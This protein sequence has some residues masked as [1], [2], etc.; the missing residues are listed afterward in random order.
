MAHELCERLY[1]LKKNPPIYF[2]QLVMSVLLHPNISDADRK[3][4]PFLI[5]NILGTIEL[6]KIKLDFFSTDILE[7]T[8]R[9]HSINAMPHDQLVQRLKQSSKNVAREMLAASNI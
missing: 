9:Y 7:I 2:S 5:Q 6:L 3:V 8:K 4:H 1:I